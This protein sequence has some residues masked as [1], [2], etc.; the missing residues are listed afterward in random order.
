MNMKILINEL[1]KLGFKE[2][3]ADII[4]LYFQNDL[5]RLKKNI[6]LDEMIKNIID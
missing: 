3:T 6:Y 4:Y 5:Q 1:V 2:K